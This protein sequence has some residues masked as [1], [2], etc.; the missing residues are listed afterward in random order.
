MVLMLQNHLLSL[1]RNIDC[2]SSAKILV[3]VL[4]GTAG[5][6]WYKNTTRCESTDKLQRRIKDETSIGFDG[7]SE[8]P[9]RI[10]SHLMDRIQQKKYLSDAK[11][12]IP[13][14]LRVLAIDVP[15]MRTEAFTGECR[16]SHDNVFLD[17]IAAP[18][19]ID[20]VLDD[21][22]KKKKQK[23]EI[24]QK[25]LVKSIVHCSSPHSQ[26]HVG[27][28]LLEASVSNFNRF[29][30]RKKQSFGKFTYDPGKYYDSS[31]GGNDDDQIDKDQMPFDKKRVDEI[32]APWNQYAWM[33]EL[34]LRINGHIKFD[35]PIER[36]PKYERV[37]YGNNYKSTVPVVYRLW[38][39]FIPYSLA[40]SDPN[41]VDGR[42]ETKMRACNK[43]HAVIANG[44]ALQLVPSSLRLLQKLCKKADVPLFVVHDPR[45]WGG[46]TQE[47]LQEALIAMRSTVKNR[48][49]SNALKQQGSS[50]F[51][52]GRVLGQ[53][54]TEV[55]WQ[56]KDKAKRMK[57]LLGLGR[58]RHQ[59]AEKEDWSAYNTNTLE[60]KLIERKVI[61]ID[62][63]GGD[64]N[65]E[66][67][68]CSP[69]VMEIARRCIQNQTGENRKE[70]DST[71]REDPD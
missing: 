21:E 30:V 42:N 65:I 26:Q 4:T 31:T 3:A 22:G 66:K 64:S 60:H 29:K 34:R 14:T 46:N 50:A 48:I 23:L 20:V 41:G 54:E 44:A 13:S 5:A 68:V 58:D 6:L 53:I 37:L 57:E 32:E 63:D 51:T 59:K 12:G 61:E 45:Q 52:R 62:S 43:P 1:S 71:L 2:G 56:L 25:S 70:Q 40:R 15:E 9:F 39:L 55:K 19:A 16:L 69:V 11:D 49:I 35:A 8:R 38:D 24:A 67:V 36:S 17:D 27:V 33:E 18:K 7:T 47:S 10:E 28:E